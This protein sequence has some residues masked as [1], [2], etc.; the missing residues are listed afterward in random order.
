MSGPNHRSDRR[1]VLGMDAELGNFIT[2]IERRTGSDAS[3]ALL[4]EINGIGSMSRNWRPCE[5][6]AVADPR[7][8]GGWGG[9]GRGY[10]GVDQRD[11]GRKFLPGNGG[12]VYIDLDHLELCIPEV[13]SAFDHVAYW[14]GMLRI[15]RGAQVRADGHLPEKH[16]LRVLVNNTDGNG[17]SWGS[18]LNLLLSRGAWERIFERRLQY[19]LFLASY[20][21]SS[22]VFT[23]AGKVGSE[24]DTPWT[25]YQISQRADFFETLCGMETTHHRPMVNSRDEG[26]CG[27]AYDRDGAND[28]SRL[29]VIFYDNNLAHGTCLLKIG[30]LQIVCAMIEAEAVDVRLVLEDPLD[31]L[32]R[33]SHDPTLQAQA[34]TCAGARRTAVELQFEFLEAARA[35]VDA[36]RAEGVVPRAAEILALWEDTLLKLRSGDL[37]ALAGRL[38]WVLKWSLLERTIAQRPKLTWRDPGLKHLDHLYSSLDPGEGLYAACE[39]GGLVEFVASEE[40]IQRAMCEPPD[41]TRAWTRAMA[42]RLAEADQVDSVDWDSLRFR[43]SRGAWKEEKRVLRMSDPLDLGRARAEEVFAGPGTDLETVLDLLG[44][45][46]VEPW[47]P[48]PS[49]IHPT[50]EN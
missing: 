45:E 27:S 15:A 26:L 30:V 1:I 37:A 11:W 25:P 14:H 6:G 47:K 36:G 19:L 10:G 17:N 50:G 13:V 35:F 5:T 4:G 44:A 42:L 49:V 22:I 46:T 7:A 34:R 31:A 23:G 32:L 39:R 3:R 2:G 24:N 38:D 16:R 29:H 9:Y 48:L 20:Q 43:F 41:E 21:A 18:H 8:H 33:W 40:Q 28:L 12:C